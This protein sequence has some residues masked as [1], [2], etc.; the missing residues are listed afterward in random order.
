MGEPAGWIC[1]G[2]RGDISPAVYPAAD[3]ISTGT[4]TDRGHRFV[5]F[6]LWRSDLHVEREYPVPCL[7]RTTRDDNPDVAR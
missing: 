7:P 4:S 3:V 5:L 2:S 1:P 6:D